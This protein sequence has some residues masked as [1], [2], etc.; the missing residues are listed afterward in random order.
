MLRTNLKIVVFTFLVSSSPLAQSSDT[1]HIA[2]FN[3]H[4]IVP[5]DNN[6]DWGER[7]YA[8]TRVLEDMNADI[9]A[10]QEMETFDGGHYSGWNLQLE[11]IV[12][13][14]TGYES[15]ALGDPEAFPSTQPII[16]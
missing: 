1:V 13:T 5:H 12:S 6:D 7:K 15:A 8:V 4:Y 14:T 10:F 3:I 2:S 11:W 16:Y 9:V